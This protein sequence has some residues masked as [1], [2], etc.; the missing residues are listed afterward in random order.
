MTPWSLA[1][2]SSVVQVVPCPT[3]R[4][5]VVVGERHCRGC[6]QR[7]DYGATPPPEPSPQEIYAALVAAGVIAAPVPPVFEP[8]PAGGPPTSTAAPTSADTDIEQSRYDDVGDVDALEVP[9]LI[10]S[11]L[12]A[13]MTPAQVDVQMIEGLEPTSAPAVVTAPLQRLEGLLD[14]DDLDIAPVAAGDEVPGLFHADMFRVDIDVPAG[15]AAAGDVLDV[16]SYS[17]RRRT[18]AQATV[19]EISRI[20]C[21]SCGTQHAEQRC[22]RCGSVR[23]A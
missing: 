15:A 9:G 23:F 22:P 2:R 14:R 4:S 12:F 7:F 6:G 16:S 18:A 1:R 11:S 10:D 20:V 8:A 13:A 21:V 17:S 19:E 3:C 5:A